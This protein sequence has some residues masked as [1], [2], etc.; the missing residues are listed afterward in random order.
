M[1]S[2]CAIDEREHFVF[3]AGGADGNH[4]HVAAAFDELVGVTSQTTETKDLGRV[5]D[6]YREPK[7]SRNP[8]DS[9]NVRQVSLVA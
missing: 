4:N 3:G 6:S 8:F 5:C 1:L 7:D 9:L 2:V